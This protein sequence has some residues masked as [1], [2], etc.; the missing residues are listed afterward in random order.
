MN[1]SPRLGPN[2]S[3]PI[4]L[5][6]QGLRV[7]FQVVY[8]EKN[9]A[10]PHTEHDHL[11]SETLFIS[12]PHEPVAMKDGHIVLSGRVSSL[13]PVTKRLDLRG[14]DYGLSFSAVCLNANELMYR[15][16]LWNREILSDDISDI[17]RFEDPQVTSVKLRGNSLL[18]AYPISTSR[19]D[20][21]NA[22]VTL[23]LKTIKCRSYID[24]VT[25]TMTP[26]YYAT[27]LKAVTQ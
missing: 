15:K 11:I 2:E 8:T 6:P 10:H 18:V 5:T 27:W 14:H 23:T 22:W 7:L 17:F 24:T 12:V 20:S 4:P 16:N 25:L 9:G 3:Y 1:G 21:V 26:V 13:V 19:S